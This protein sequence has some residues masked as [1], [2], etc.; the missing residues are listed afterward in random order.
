MHRAHRGDELLDRAVLE[1]IAG[2]AGVH[3]AAQVARPG[4]GRHD[5][6]PRGAAAPAQLGGDLEAGQ[7]RHLD[8]GQQHVGPQLLDPA[9]G[10]RAVVGVADHLDV[11]LQAQQRGQRARDELL[12]FGD[13][14]ADQ[15]VASPGR[16]TTSRVP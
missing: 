12:V 9:Q 11:G 10:G 7:Q 8:V 3:R 15:G 1:Q 4:E 16:V 5:D 2:H 14:D 6:D 13:Q